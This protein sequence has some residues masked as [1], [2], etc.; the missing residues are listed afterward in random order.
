M[1]QLVNLRGYCRWPALSVLV[2]ALLWLS[3][4][5]RPQP[6]ESADA[7][8]DESDVATAEDAPEER[9]AEPVPVNPGVASWRFESEGTVFQGRLYR[10]LVLNGNPVI[11][12][13]NGDA[14]N[15]ALAFAGEPSGLQTVTKAT[16]AN[17]RG[18]I[19]EQ[20]GETGSFQ[21]AFE[22]AEAGWLTGRFGGMLGC[23]DYRLMPVA[24]S[25]HIQAPGE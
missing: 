21:I 22:P 17:G 24:G 20:V 12:L 3:A 23:P 19:C 13:F 14:V 8:V 25:F 4:C 5:D 15:L 7:T 11:Q 6:D 9:T 10:H 16:F 18:P 2:A 1:T